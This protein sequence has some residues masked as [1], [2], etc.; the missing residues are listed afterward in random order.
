[1]INAIIIY[2]YNGYRKNLNPDESSKSSIEMMNK[3]EEETK[4]E[5]FFENEC[6]TDQKRNHQNGSSSG[7]YVL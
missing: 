7:P 5:Q 2:C 4:R 6:K 3:E 1:M